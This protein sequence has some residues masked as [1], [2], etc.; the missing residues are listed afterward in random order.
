M[1]FCLAVPYRSRPLLFAAIAVAIAGIAACDPTGPS[2]AATFE[3]IWADQRWTGDARASGSPDATLF[4][5]GTSP[6]NAGSMPLTQVTIVVTLDGPGT[7][8]LGPDDARF[9]YLVGGDV[10]TASYT[11]GAAQSGTVV[12]ETIS[13]TEV[14]GSVTFT[15]ASR[16]EHSPVGD[17]ARFEGT[18]RA[19]ISM[20]TILGS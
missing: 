20:F 6:V 9:T 16:Y 17:I 14:T 2:P 10:I 1:S 12:I 11:L 18:F 7:Y 5:D 3:G 4:I 15:A 13:A 19:P 8:E